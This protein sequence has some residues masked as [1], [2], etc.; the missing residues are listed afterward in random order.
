MSEWHFEGAFMFSNSLHGWRGEGVPLFTHL[1]VQ[2]EWSLSFP[3][4]V[5][6]VKISVSI[7]CF[8]FGK[9][10]FRGANSLLRNRVGQWGERGL[11][12]HKCYIY[13]N[14]PKMHKFPLTFK[15]LWNQ[16]ASY[17][18][19]SGKALSSFREVCD[20]FCWSAGGNINPGPLHIQFP[21]WGFLKTTF[22]VW[23][24]AARLFGFHFG[25]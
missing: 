13:Y 10:A 8:P 20:C 2:T 17:S 4:K 9:D 22:S 19:W 24:Q 3:T 7:S 25:V 12:S 6:T 21:D 11:W 14:N 16:D 1:I 18:P 5:P 23:N 15:P